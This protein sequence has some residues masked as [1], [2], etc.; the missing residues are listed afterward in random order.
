MISLESNIPGI[1]ENMSMNKWQ[2]VDLLEDKD[3]I[4]REQDETSFFLGFFTLQDKSH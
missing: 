4:K 3:Y 2:S 1:L